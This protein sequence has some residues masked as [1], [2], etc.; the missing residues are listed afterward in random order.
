[1]A[2]NSNMGASI[3]A[4][5]DKPRGKCRKW[6]ITVSLGRDETGKYRQK[7]RNFAGTYTEAKAEALRMKALAD[8][9]RLVARKSYT[10]AEYAEHWNDVRAASGR[11]SQASVA[12]DRR[13]LRAVCHILGQLK[14]Q[15]VTPDMLESAYARLRG[16]ETLSGKP[17]GGTYVLGIHKKM[18]AMYAYA[19]DH[20]VV[21][22][23]PCRKAIPPAPDTAERRAVPAAQLHALVAALDP[24][25]PLQFGV[26]LASQLGLRRGEIVGLSRGDFDFSARVVRIRH[27]Y[28]EVGG[29]KDTKNRSSLRELPMTD[30]VAEAA[31]ARINRMAQDFAAQ[32]LTNLLAPG[33]QP[34][35][36]AA[37][38]AAAALDVAPEAA[39][40]CTRRGV[41][42][43]PGRLSSW[44]AKARASYGAEGVKLHELRHTFITAG[45]MNGVDIGTLQKL[46]GHA[47]PNV[48]LGV[49][50]HA[51]MDAKR[52][53]IEAMSLAS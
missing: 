53:A 20:G 30:F 12:R 4:L 14:L 51:A 39:M 11:Y 43:R 42:L 21:A 41:R 29:L 9:G 15:D 34:N 33:K 38:N 3:R 52:A 8:E 31:R 22:E 45:V 40:L 28:T 50:T 27:A 5:E 6:K 47:N 35:A 2:R 49:Y 19:V 17:A 32:G 16:G 1:M 36:A 7:S 48:L 24:A 46:S 13:L 25:D 37:G 26:L 23:N 44:W 10:F 18:S